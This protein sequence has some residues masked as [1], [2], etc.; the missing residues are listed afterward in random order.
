MKITPYEGF[1]MIKNTVETMVNKAANIDYKMSAGIEV[2]K[3]PDKEVLGFM[4][5]FKKEH[6]TVGYAG[7]C[8]N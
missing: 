5:D 2:K 8:S 6:E 3:N 7:S 4:D 1:E